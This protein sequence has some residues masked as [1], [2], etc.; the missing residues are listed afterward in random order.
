MAGPRRSSGPPWRS[1]VA[2]SRGRGN[3]ASAL[4]DLGLRHDRSKEQY[5][6]HHGES[7]RQGARP[8]VR[9]VVVVVAFSLAIMASACG[10]NDAKTTTVAT[11][12]DASA[13]GCPNGPFDDK[14][15][16]VPQGLKPTGT[17]NVAGWYV[18]IAGANL[19]VRLVSD[20]AKPLAA[21]P[22]TAAGGGDVTLSYTGD[23]RGSGSLGKLTAVPDQ[24]AGVVQESAG[25]VTFALNGQ[26][27]PVGFDVVIPCGVKN[28]RLTLNLPSAGKPTPAPVAQIFLG[29]SSHPLANPVVLARVG[30]PTAPTST[31]TKPKATTTTAKP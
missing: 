30:D 8:G 11:T 26:T 4:L 15:Q 3:D 22:T 29:P 13:K 16:G 19:R 27:K 31:T 25:K 6:N 23:L 20:P 14:A 2:G 1:K 17:G 18:W 28:L 24:S 5:L 10:K 7:T 21:V 12:E 9:I